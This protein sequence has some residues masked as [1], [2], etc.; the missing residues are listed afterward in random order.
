MLFKHIEAKDMIYKD[1]N[2]HISSPY[3]H[4]QSE[5]IFTIMIVRKSKKKKKKKKKKTDTSVNVS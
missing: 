4:L 1:K 3:D 2:K 5:N